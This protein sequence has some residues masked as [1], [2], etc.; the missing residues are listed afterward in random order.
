MVDG[1]RIILQGSH[2][3]FLYG[4]PITTAQ[5]KLQINHGSIQR[6]VTDRQGLVRL[7]AEQAAPGALRGSCKIA[8]R[9][10]NVKARSG[11]LICPWRAAVRDIPP[12]LCEP[13]S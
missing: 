6:C 12:P 4:T 7:F 8:L 9:R 1:I 5:L 13:P 2:T 3:S 11:Q 10:R